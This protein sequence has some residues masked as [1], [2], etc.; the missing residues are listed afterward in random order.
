MRQL[1]QA[2]PS[3][4]QTAF[5]VVQNG[6]QESRD[7]AGSTNQ[8]THMIH[9]SMAMNVVDAVASVAVLH[10]AHNIVGEVSCEDI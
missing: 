4:T 1:Q 2:R 6:A 9:G 3:A 5:G 8:N 10:P 7:G